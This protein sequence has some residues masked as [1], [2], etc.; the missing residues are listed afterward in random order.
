[1]GTLVDSRRIDEG[2]DSP[3]NGGG[4]GECGSLDTRKMESPELLPLPPLARQSLGPNSLNSGN[5][6]VGSTTTADDEEEEFYS[7]R[8]SS[9][10][11][12]SGSTRVFACMA[13]G[14]FPGRRSGGSSSCTSCSSSSSASPNRSHSISSS[15]GRP[16][17]FKSPESSVNL[18][19]PSPPPPPPPPQPHNTRS[20]VDETK[21][22]SPSL[23]LHSSPERVVG[24]NS[25]ESTPP[26]VSNASHQNNVRSP[27]LSP[28][29]NSPDRALNDYPDAFDGHKQSPLLSSASSSPERVL[30]KNPDASPIILVGSGLKKQ[31]CSSSLYS[32]SPEESPRVSNASEKK[33]QLL[34]LSPERDLEEKNPDDA[35]AGVLFDLDPQ[36]RSLSPSLSPE[37]VM[38]KNLD[39][40]SPRVSVASSDRRRL[41]PSP[42][43]SSLPSSSSETERVMENYAENSPPRV[44]NASSDHK[45]LCLSPS[46]PPSSSPE[47][48]LEKN[49]DASPR[50][51]DAS[52]G[53]LYD[54]NLNR[55]SLS[56]SPAS[57]SPERDFHNNSDESPRTSNDS[58]Q[59]VVSPV[60]TISALK[61]P[62]LR[63]PP[64]PP[65]PPPP[66]FKLYRS[67]P[68]TLLTPTGQTIC[69]PPA[70]IPP[71]RPFVVQ[72]TSSV[73]ISPMELPPI[74]KSIENVEET[75]KPKLKPLHWDK[76]RASSDREMVW[77]QLRS[78]SFK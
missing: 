39:A 69:K 62:P 30:E 51:S 24:K 1:M 19:A 70:L 55:R 43:L 52:D 48:V 20:S 73:A 26:R 60:G 16:E 76:V 35:S 42:S 65:P 74:S 50:V 77:D 44:S 4:G 49:P 7:P 75:P 61:Q 57:S 41:S 67:E 22:V 3:N 53:I 40:S 54:L 64:P 32:S 59:N 10:G 8:G 36:R 29:S 28:L 56:S 18:Q 78:S 9:I 68:P 5:A 63:I 34:S 15:P 31:S 23:S 72:N 14:N 66:P 25:A 58:D 71:S 12:G 46:T 21:V 11:T 6:D 33:L 37:R 47:R 45:R 17:S 13:G 27:S 2:V 38:E